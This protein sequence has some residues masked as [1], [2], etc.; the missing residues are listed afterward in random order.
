P[1]QVA[2]RVSRT[3]EMQPLLEEI[4]NEDGRDSER[5]KRN[6]IGRYLLFDPDMQ[7]LQVEKEEE[8]HDAERVKAPKEAAA[9][10][11]EQGDSGNGPGAMPGTVEIAAPRPV[12]KQRGS[13]RTSVGDGGA[14]EG[15]P[16]ARPIERQN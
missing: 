15:L 16:D 13:S 4:A 2:K 3:V 14:P 8:D 6:C 1:D 5:P 7:I 10:K 9:Q 12:R 11:H